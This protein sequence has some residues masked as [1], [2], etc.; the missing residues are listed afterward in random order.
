VDI[1]NNRVGHLMILPFCVLFS[2]VGN[3]SKLDSLLVTVTDVQKYLHAH[4]TDAEFIAETAPFHV[5]LV[6]SA[7]L[8]FDQVLTPLSASQ[9]PP[10]QQNLWVG[11]LRLLNSIISLNP[12]NFMSYWQQFLSDS[13]RVDNAIASECAKIQSAI[14]ESDSRSECSA[15][16]R[17]I[18]AK[19]CIF[20]AVLLPAA[21]NHYIRLEGVKCLLATVSR[22][23]LQHWF[24]G[25]GSK[26]GGDASPS[27]SA[28]LKSAGSNLA[29]KV[30]YCSNMS[31]FAHSFGAIL[32][33]CNSYQDYENDDVVTVDGYAHGNYREGLSAVHLFVLMA[34]IGII[35]G[36][37]GRVFR[38][39]GRFAS[40]TH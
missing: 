19:S 28:K 5:N 22:L 36:N 9:L 30:L 39:A 31:V 16:I 38:A 3:D 12:Q 2:C 26:P 34:L 14:S 23:P 15:R 40:Q 37:L 1:R 32:G 21:D 18:G 13:G 27:K 17:K 29:E 11:S 6:Q 20:S 35:A 33:F 8:L 4:L 25:I 10:V 7:Q 24:R